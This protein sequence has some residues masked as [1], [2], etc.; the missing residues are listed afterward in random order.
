MEGQQAAGNGAPEEETKGGQAAGADE[1]TKDEEDE[2][3]NAIPALGTKGA[4]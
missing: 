4:N 1:E 3:L 2:D